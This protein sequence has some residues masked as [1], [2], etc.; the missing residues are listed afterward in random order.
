MLCPEAVLSQTAHK[1]AVQELCTQM[2]D[3]HLYRG[4]SMCQIS[5]LFTGVP[6]PFGNSLEQANHFSVRVLGLPQN[7][8]WTGGDRVPV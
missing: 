1:Q 4:L 7:L 6:L 5:G 2:F 3:R 8:N